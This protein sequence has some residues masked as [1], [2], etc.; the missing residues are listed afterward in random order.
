MKKYP[1]KYFCLNDPKKIIFQW[2][3]PIHE[4]YNE[5]LKH[6]NIKFSIKPSWWS[7][8]PNQT[9]SSSFGYVCMYLFKAAIICV[10]LSSSS[11]IT[12]TNFR[13]LQLY[14]DARTFLHVRPEI[15][16]WGRLWALHNIIFIYSKCLKFM[17]WTCK[18][19]K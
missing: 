12:F 1:L 14:E 17:A 2:I 18:G 5:T 6:N 16:S 3:F 8:D 13:G 19:D 15:K 10:Y 9:T 4:G 7:V 11:Q